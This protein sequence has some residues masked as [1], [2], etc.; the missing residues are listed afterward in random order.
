M[1]KDVCD[2]LGYANASDAVI[3]H[4]KNNG[5]VKHDSVN[6]VGK[7][8][9]TIFINE[10]NLMRLVVKSKLPAAE[11]FEAWVF[12]EVLPTIRKTG[13]YEAPITTPAHFTVVIT[14]ELRLKM[15]FKAPSILHSAVAMAVVI[16]GRS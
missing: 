14:V 7:K 2:V 5:I 13:K 16:C 8:Y 11:K 4:C 10:P 9:Q 6:S 15:P 12:D 3:R 1:A